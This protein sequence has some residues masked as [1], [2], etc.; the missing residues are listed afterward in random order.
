[1][2]KYAFTL[3]YILGLY[4]GLHAQTG[5]YPPVHFARDTNL[6]DPAPWKL[7]FEDNFDGDRID[8]TKWITYCSYPGMPGGDNEHWSG[9]RS[10]GEHSF[11]FRD[12]NVIVND[13]TCKLLLRR[14]TNTWVCTNCKDPVIFRRHASCGM[15]GTRRNLTDG[16]DNAYNNGRLEARIRFPAFQGAWCA[17][18][19]W[20][21]LGVNEIDIAEA[22][23]GKQI[24]SNQRRNKY[25]SHAWGPEPYT[26][27]PEPNPYQVP[28]DAALG[29]KFPGQGWWNARF[30]RNY[31]RQE[32]W[33]TYTCA[34]DDNQIR[35][36]IDSALLTSSW[37]YIKDMGYA[38]NGHNYTLT[39]GS[40][41]NPGKDTAYYLN[42]GFPHNTRSASQVLLWGRVDHQIGLNRSDRLSGK[43]SVLN[44]ELL[45]R[46]EIDYVKIWQRHPEQDNHKELTAAIR[47][48]S[49]IKDYDGYACTPAAHKAYDIHIVHTRD[50]KNSSQFQLFESTCIPD[51]ENRSDKPDFEWDISITNG[52]DTI[53]RYY[54]YYGQFVATPFV[55]DSEDKNFRISWRLKI[56]DHRNNVTE[57]TGA[58]QSDTSPYPQTN[59]F[60]PNCFEALISDRDAYEQKVNRLVKQ[61]TLSE[62]QSK[63]AIA[64]NSMIEQI[65]AEEL[66]PYLDSAS[67]PR[68]QFTG[69]DLVQ[70]TGR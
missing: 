36:Y 44:P 1:M 33:H 49:A 28:Y 27:P 63:D 52:Y 67:A 60:P 57:K 3:I 35:Y 32:D 43:D 42:F 66:Q 10:G 62:D 68:T 22:W 69:Q 20:H 58:W 25:G 7:V 12:E 38:Y 16:T 9:A 65:R 41:C 48:E 19:T 70:H 37:K 30:N 24:G 29:Y 46:M 54:K 53:P 59:A 56:T 51:M 15:I 18:W 47:A 13:G 4:M 64:I 14:E 61:H 6:C 34:W 26:K 21:G 23:G 31:H 40:G 11:I 39:I 55:A 17:F 45:G 8:K 5:W 2:K 50:L